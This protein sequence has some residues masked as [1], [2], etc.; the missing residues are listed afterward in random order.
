MEFLK[1]LEMHRT[2]FLNAFFNLVTLPG[3]DTVLVVLIA[4]VYFIFSKE[5]AKKVLFI[6]LVSL[7]I[8][9][10]I[11]NLV[12][13]PRPFSEGKVSCLRPETATG[14]SFPS[15]HTQNFATWSS[16]FALSIKN[17]LLLILSILMTI[18]VAFSRMY[19]GA[20]YPGDVLTGAVLGFGMSFVF[21]VLYS[22]V[23]NID[24]IYKITFLIVTPFA[25]FF[26]LKPDILFEDFFKT[27]GMT[28]GFI[29]AVK[30]EETFVSL[31]NN[32]SIFKRI[33]RVF[34]C[35]LLVLAEKKLIGLLPSPEN[36]SVALILDSLK[37]FLIVLAGFALCPLLFKKIKI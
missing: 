3:E 35:I 22:K 26:S 33:L 10:I 25:L 2:S 30:F 6:T 31:S 13:L 8:N 29:C 21:N 15:G 23:K 1:F 27:Y 11:K 9:G 37:Y 5:S 28:A 14:Y 16:A 19:L 34:I 32:T 12:K 24:L 7:N 20:H 4:V 17:N 36:V 18:L